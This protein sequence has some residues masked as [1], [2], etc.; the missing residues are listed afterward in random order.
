VFIINVALAEIKTEDIV[1]EEH[2]GSAQRRS[3]SCGPSVKR[4]KGA[5]A[6]TNDRQSDVSV[7]WRSIY[8][9]RIEW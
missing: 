5:L 3:M 9:G 7:M 4:K 8:S 1:E 2:E 6:Y